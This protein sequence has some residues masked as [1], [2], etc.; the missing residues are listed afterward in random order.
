[1]A[2]LGTTQPQNLA[3][4][5]DTCTMGGVT[6]NVTGS[7]VYNVPYP[8]SGGTLPGGTETFTMKSCVKPGHVAKLRR[9]LRNVNAR[10]EE[11][12][13]LRPQVVDC[14][15]SMG[16]Q[17]GWASCEGAWLALSNFLGT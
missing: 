17:L 16:L 5:Y 2:F 14:H 9:K 6:L 15:H 11:H 7:A 13:I 1:M 3:G 8:C 10:S 4:Y 12:C